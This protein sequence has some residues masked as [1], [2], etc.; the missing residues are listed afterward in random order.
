VIISRAPFR[1]SLGGGGTD[2]PSYYSRYGGFLI[3][4]GINK[5]VY[6]SVNRRF[7]DS[8]RLSYSQTEI[9]ESVEDIQHHIFRETFKYLG[10]ER[11]IEAVS[12]ADMPANSGLG[13]SS[14]FTVALLNALHAYRREY[15]S[16]EQLAEEACHIELDLLKQPIGKQ[17]QYIAAFGGI[18]CLTFDKDGKVLVER[19]NL[20]EDILSE[21]QYRLVMFYSGKERN[22]ADILT[23]QDRKTK[24]LDPQTT[25]ALH[26]IKEIGLETRRQ[27]ERGRI[28]SLGE[29]MDEHWKTKKQLST[30]ISDDYID[31]CYDLARKNGA[32]GGKIMGAG[33]GGFFL[34][35]VDP[36][37][38]RRLIDAV[39][40]VGLK[41]VDFDFDYQGAKII[42][43]VKP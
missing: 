38:K 41:H 20:P 15:M 40:P 28:D 35:F 23:E 37:K 11:G 25:S 8:I 13:S 14:C 6:L 34:F 12:V 22:S 42:F 27:L 10:V 3:G 31:E 5:Y 29:L 2:L 17:D 18:T 33:G 36:G 4:A 43:N 21:L 32:S 16:P 24:E 1:I 9:V 7:Y 39:T 26:R 19:L 30:A